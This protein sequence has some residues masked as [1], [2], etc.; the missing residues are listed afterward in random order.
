[1]LLIKELDGRGLKR[2]L[3]ATRAAYRWHNK[4]NR[5]GNFGINI[6]GIAG[7]DFEITGSYD[8]Q[9]QI[10]VLRFGYQYRA[11]VPIPFRDREQ[12]ITIIKGII[13][14]LEELT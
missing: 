14:K 11:G 8:D 13:K 7:K 1:M 2:D 6:Y 4:N 5:G 10:C 12:V 3:G 9:G